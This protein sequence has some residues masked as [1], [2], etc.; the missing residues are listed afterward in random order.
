MSDA[1]ELGPVEMVVLAFPGTRV[2]AAV[3]SALAEVVDRGYVTVLDL[4]YLAMDDAGVV[5]QIEVDESLT[6]TGL[7]GVTVDPRGLVSDADLDVVREAM[8]PGTSAVVIVYEE[9]WAR[10]LAGTVRGAGGEV[11]L[12]VQIPRDAVDA[13]LSVS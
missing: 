2:D 13:A 5:R 10:K 4:I 11:A 1:T 8:D 12:H 3:T 9:S 6:E 7:D